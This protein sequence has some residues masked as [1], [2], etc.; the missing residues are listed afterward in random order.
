M[1]N[2]LL[3]KV[4]LQST[5]GLA[6]AARRF[7]PSPSD[8]YLVSYPRSG[9]TW[10]RA[11]IAEIMFGESGQSLLDLNHYVPDIYELPPA[12]D[13]WPA[14]WHVVKTH[15]TYQYSNR[16]KFERVIYILRDPRDVALSYHRYQTALKLY[17]AS[18]DDFLVD[19]L[20]GRIWPGSWREHVMSWAGPWH[21]PPPTAIHIFR[22]ED[23]LSNVEKNISAI[24]QLLGYPLDPS[25][26]DAVVRRTTPDEMRRK[27]S[28]SMCRREY[29][30][31]SHRF[32]GQAKA[33]GWREALT[34]RQKSLVADD[35]G[36]FM[37]RFGYEC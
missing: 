9:N 23:L 11:V 25:R 31:G 29:P 5:G 17:A 30:E 3:R 27:E 1:I 4:G 8:V 22:Y 13:L 14:D 20:A 12:D 26:L 21:E 18:F 34:D 24:G 28:E 2:S 37:K 6:Q 33:N 35:L 7:E 16:N 32:V 36:D 15:E 19:W 10:L